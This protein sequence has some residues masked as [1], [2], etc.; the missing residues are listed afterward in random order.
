MGYLSLNTNN[1]KFYCF[2]GEP[3]LIRVKG[4]FN[5]TNIYNI[6]YI[7][8]TIANIEFNFSDYIKDNTNLFKKPIN[9]ENMLNYSR[10]LSADFCFCRVDFYEVNSII[11]LSE[12]TFSPFNAHIKYKTKD[13]EIYLGSLLNISK[14]K[15]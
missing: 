15:K 1:Y 10:L 11:Y 8:W 13:M 12:L 14:I 3:K 6:Y 4:K 5:G 7:N 9:Y 2:N